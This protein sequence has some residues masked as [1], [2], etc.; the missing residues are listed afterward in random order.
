VEQHLAWSHQ[1]RAY[2]DVYRHLTVP[3]PRQAATQRP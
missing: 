3:S 1:R 2:L